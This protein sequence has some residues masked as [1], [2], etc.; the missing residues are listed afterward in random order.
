[1]KVLGLDIGTNSIGWGLIEDEKQEI[2]A[3]GVRIFPVGVNI[4]T[5]FKEESKGK[6]RRIGRTSRRCAFRRK[7]RINELKTILFE[8]GIWSGHPSY[9]SSILAYQLRS[10][11]LDSLLTLEELAI[12]LLHIARRR[13]FQSGKKDDIDLKSLIRE[14]E[15]LLHIKDVEIENQVEEEDDDDKEEKKVKAGI[16]EL[17]KKIAETKAR[18]LGEYFYQLF[19]KEQ[20]KEKCFNPEQ[21]SERIRARYTSREMYKY[22][23]E[24]ILKKQQSY[25]HDVLSD[26]TVKKIW[27]CIFFQRKLKSQKHLI[28]QCRYESQKRCSPISKPIYQEFRTWDSICNIRVVFAEDEPTRPLSL[29]EKEILYNAA[30]NSAN[31]SLTDVRELVFGGKR[32]EINFDE[33]GKVI[34]NITRIKIINALLGSARV[35]EIKKRAENHPSKNPLLFDELLFEEIDKN[36]LNEYL[37]GEVYERI[38]HW[39]HIF[40]SRSWLKEKLEKEFTSIIQKPTLVKQELSKLQ[41]LRLASMTIEKKFGS[42]S[43][44]AIKKLLP[45]MK[46]EGGNLTTA[47]QAQQYTITTEEYKYD[48]DRI[49][50]KEL[51]FLKINELRNP[52]VQRALSEMI[53]LVNEIIKK[54]GQFDKDGNLDIKTVRIET[55]RELRKPKKAREKIYKENNDKQTIRRAYAKFLTNSGL[56]KEKGEILPSDPLVKKYELWLELYPI[57]SEEFE[58]KKDKEDF[59]ELDSKM[60]KGEIKDMGTFAKGFLKFADNIEKPEN[61]KFKLWL[62][63]NRISVYS[64]KPISLAR[65]LQK[66][67]DIQIDHIVPLKRSMN[68]DFANK[69]LCEGD[70]N[71]EKKDRTPYEYFMQ[72]HGKGEWKAFC[73]RIKKLPDYKQ[74]MLKLEQFPDEEWSKQQFQ[75][76]AY[77]ARKAKQILSSVFKDVETVKGQATAMLRRHWKLNYL[78]NKEGKDI[79]E[80]K[81]NRHHAVDAVVIALTT[82]ELLNNHLTKVIK[83]NNEREKFVNI[84]YSR[85]KDRIDI[86]QESVDILQEP[87][88]NNQLKEQVNLHLEKLL[89]SHKSEERL[90]SK[91]RAKTLIGKKVKTWISKNGKLRK[92]VKPIFKLSEKSIIAPRGNLHTQPYRQITMPFDNHPSGYERG[93]KI[94][95][96]KILVAEIKQVDIANVL[97][98]ITQKQLRKYWAEKA[99][100]KNK[101]HEVH[102]KAYS[103]PENDFDVPMHKVTVIMKKQPSLI[104]I[105]PHTPHRIFVE[106]D[107]NY[108]IGIYQ[109][110]KTDKKGKVTISSKAVAVNFIDA[111]R[112]KR[113]KKPL[114]ADEFESIKDK[115]IYGLKRTIKKGDMFIRYDKSPDEIANYF[116]DDKEIF[117]RLYKLTAMS[118]TQTDGIDLNLSKHYVNNMTKIKKKEDD[119]NDEPTENNTEKQEKVDK[120][121]KY[122]QNNAFLR[123][124]SIANFKFVKVRIDILG[125]ISI[126]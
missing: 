70:I 55:M 30:Q 36:G 99:Q 108:I 91:R 32:V 38:W 123:I 22:E 52:I 126:A 12:V 74:E 56:G 105:R 68:N 102:A 9:K 112:A 86:K 88:R 48:K 49:L 59:E 97:D 84:N 120:I 110:E 118:V 17:N 96:K 89:V 66:N 109:A 106:S 103:K 19:L 4:S 90:Y 75:N 64:G 122:T 121:E 34:G 82:P 11:G 23:F 40:D 28:N 92:K 81:D 61:T 119:G 107:S 77:T 73:A 76:N 39:L 98:L 20:A 94:V 8:M 25:Y 44:Y 72:E 71:N 113:A 37:Q 60:K 65:L 21:P 6:N 33:D 53:K 7:K 29:S 69:I 114:L 124:R 63:S 47:C 43:E 83:Y 58:K 2:I 115:L 80:R 117:N 46:K 51:A 125:R 67:S 100:A 116:D 62:E 57:P 14:E 101:D 16:N 1:M 27:N 18:T 85:D 45:H 41:I 3:M 79:K 24:E 35:E 15:K 42:I 95:V 87:W 78:L 13:G 5:K 50:K 10:K 93:E 26:D 104:E 54:Y 111:I 31:L